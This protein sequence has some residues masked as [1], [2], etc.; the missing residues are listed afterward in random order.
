MDS[1]KIENLR[2]VGAAVRHRS[3]GSGVIEELNRDVNG[4]GRLLEEL[5]K[6]RRDEKAE[7]FMAYFKKRNKI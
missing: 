7:E 1:A 4:A 5:L 6:A 2:L 3:F